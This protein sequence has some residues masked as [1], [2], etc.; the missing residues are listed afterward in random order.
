MTER[1]RLFVAVLPP[2][3]VL[4][5]LAALPR[6]D[7][8]NVRYTRRDQWHVTLRFLG[9]CEVS[10]ALAAFETIDGAAAQAEL[11][12]SVQRLGRSIVIVPVEGLDDLAAVVVGATRDV[13]EP[14]DPRPFRGHITIARLR[15]R[16]ACRVAGHRIRATFR[17]DEVHLVRSD[18]R[19]DGAVYETVATRPLR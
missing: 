6:A 10:R 16:T 17:V 19:P 13:G 4:D 3:D 11:G 7:E 15:G 8:P 2:D 14:P 18:L 5:L 12:P 1:A 9:S